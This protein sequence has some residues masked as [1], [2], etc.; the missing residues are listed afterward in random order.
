MFTKRN[1]PSTNASYGGIP[2]GGPKRSMP[3]IEDRPRTIPL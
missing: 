3:A 2:A 1:M